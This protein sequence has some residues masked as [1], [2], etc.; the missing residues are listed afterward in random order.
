[1]KTGISAE[2]AAHYASGA[3]TT[4]RLWKITRRDGA[5]FGFTD[6]DQAITYLSVDYEP[7]SAFDASAVSTR[8]ELNVDNLEVVGLLDSEGI[9]VQDIEAGVWDGAR[10]VLVEVNYKDLTMGHNTLRTGQIGQI[11]R[12]GLTFVAELRG[13]MQTLQNN[14]GRVVTASC[15]AD[16]GDARCGVDL[17]ALRVSGTV[18]TGASQIAFTASGLA[19]AANYFT[20]GVVTWVTGDNAGR[21]MEVKLHS[22]GGVFSL[23]LDMPNTIDAGDTFTVTPGCNK[24]GRAGDCKVKF[25]NLVNF[26]GFEDVPGQKKVLIYG[27]Q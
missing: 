7:S 19:Q 27:G 16:L 9:T 4:A 17:E 23:Q 6:H 13:L 26:R 11:P 5:V 2:L 10:F 14:I 1:V 15:D 8:S 3:E 21:S 25:D 24:V 20:Y 18:T 12:K 22:G